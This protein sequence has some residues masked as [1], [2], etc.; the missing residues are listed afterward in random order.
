M[1]YIADHLQNR[2]HQEILLIGTDIVRGR[3]EHLSNLL[4]IHHSLRFLNLKISTTRILGWFIGQ[5]SSFRLLFRVQYLHGGV[6]HEFELAVNYS[7][8][9]DRIDSNHHVRQNC[10]LLPLLIFG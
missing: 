10:Q 3:Y 9:T 8:Q 1:M 4:S 5:I 2:R 6:S 7:F